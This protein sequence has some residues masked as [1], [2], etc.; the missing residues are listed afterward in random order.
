MVYS[1]AEDKTLGTWRE[2]AASQCISHSDK[3]QGTGLA[4][5][6]IRY[7]PIRTDRANGETGISDQPGGILTGGILD[8]LIVDTREQLAR[9]A[10]HLQRLEALREQLT[11]SKK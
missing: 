4:S 8:Q 3:Y 9:T 11:Y 6:A 5:T 1:N 10:E 7:Q 2:Q